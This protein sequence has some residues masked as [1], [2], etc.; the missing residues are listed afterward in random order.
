[1]PPSRQTERGDGDEAVLGD[2]PARG[3]AALTLRVRD[4]E[5]GLH[6]GVLGGARA[7]AQLAPLVVVLLWIAPRLALAALLVFAP[8]SSALAASRSWWK[9]ANTSAAL[10]AEALLEAADEAVRHAD[11]WTT[12]GAQAKARAN[13]ARLGEAIA[14]LSARLEASTAAMSGANEVLG[15]L[16]LVGALGAAGAG[17]LGDAGGG[18]AL[19]SFT[20]AFFLAYRPIRDLTEARLALGRAGVAFDELNRLAPVV[21][22]EP[23]SAP[24]KASESAPWPLAALEVHAL[25]L[26]CG[27]G[28]PVSFS[29]QP[30][31]IVA[32]LGP[33]GSGKTTLLRAL[34]GLEVTLSGEVRYAGVS[35][36]S[37]P[38]GPDSRPFAWVPQ[39][40]PLLADTLAA[41][42]G[43]GA[44]A[45][46]GEALEP[47]GASYLV[48]ALGSDRLGA[49]GRAVSGGERQWIALARALATRQPVLLLDEPTSGMDPLAQARV[50]DAIARLRGSRTI[51]LVTHR[52]EPLAIA[53]R[54]V[55]LG[56]RIGAA[57]PVAVTRTDAREPAPA[58]RERCAHG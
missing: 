5:A 35:L 8:F 55:H 38:P 52:P 1:M 27:A 41:N 12:Y 25:R 58:S 20:V 34:L 18:G 2:S 45:D 47:L 42:I 29:V 32:V 22:S 36:D 16:A 13:V 28:A 46:P 17:W 53:D 23:E 33:T 49:G 51:I 31:Q 44:P 6:S 21:S 9:R 14:R 57:P 39:E 26:S 40:A 37:A 30:G 43:L 56:G 48:S 19:L 54:I 7:V 15:A 24:A 4:V 10:S 3:V 11:L 50:L